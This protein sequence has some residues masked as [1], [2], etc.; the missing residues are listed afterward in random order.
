MT[1]IA[2]LLLLL[3]GAPLVLFALSARSPQR[4]ENFTGAHL[5]TGPMAI[6]MALAWALH[7]IAAPLPSTWANVLLALAWPG[8]VVTLTM[9]PLAAH[10]RG[11]AWT[12]KLGCVLAAVSII[13][14]GH[15]AALHPAMP[16]LGAAGIGFFGLGGTLLLAQPWLRPLWHKLRLSRATGPDEPS[17]FDA[18][19]SAWQREQWQQL[20]ADA[21]VPALLAHTRSLAP[22]VRQACLARLAARDDLTTAVAALLEGSDPESVLHYLAHDYPKPRAPLA[23]ATAAM[24]AGVRTRW[25]TRLRKDRDKR[26]WTGEV[27]P[28]LE[29]GIAV[30]REGGDVRAELE[31]WQR[32]LATMPPLADLAKELARQ[33]RAPHAHRQ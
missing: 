4:P 31:T 3:A 12:A 6:G 18:K 30:L 29:C 14:L 7:L 8:F 1:W 28:A 10:G 19:Q 21:G 20:P 11:R 16:R 17:S 15:G 24:L 22:D 32:E 26:P 27:V 5:I 2:D 13:V 9:L 23:A 33:L 25:V